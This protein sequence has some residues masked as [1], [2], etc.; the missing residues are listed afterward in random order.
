[1]ELVKLI[2]V[3]RY[4]VDT[5]FHILRLSEAVPMRLFLLSFFF[6]QNMV[7]VGYDTPMGEMRGKC[8]FCLF[9]LTDGMHIQIPI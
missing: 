1:M 4:S 8:I 7:H 2:C 6:E 9:I 3:H 5:F